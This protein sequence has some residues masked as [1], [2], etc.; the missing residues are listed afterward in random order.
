MSEKNSHDATQATTGF[1][2]SWL[3]LREPADHRARNTSLDHQLIRWFKQQNDH[4]ILE[5]GAGTGSNL[6]YL[7]PQLGHDQNWL[8]LDNDAALFARLPDLLQAWATSHDAR[9]F[10]DNKTWRIEHATFSANIKCHVI[11]LASQLEQIP[12]DNIQLLTGSA[13]LDLTSA[14]WL[15]KIAAWVTQQRCACLFALNYDGKIHWSPEQES[16]RRVTSLLNEHQLNDKGFGQALGPGAGH[17]FVQ[18]LQQHGRHVLAEDSDW[19]IEPESSALQMA[20]IDGWAPA[21]VEQDISAKDAI[22]GWHTER[23][24]AITQGLSTLTVGHIDVL[25]LP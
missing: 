1:S 8:L 15:D 18:C 24:Q 20:I 21:A 13:L 14:T 9:F 4:H 25:S 22:L 17:Y 6:R 16:D 10:N 23:R 19:V 12:S 3:A 2:E 7:L 5:L 11:N